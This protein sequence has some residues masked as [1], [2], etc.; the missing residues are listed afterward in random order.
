[1]FFVSIGIF[2][3]KD[4]YKLSTLFPNDL[5]PL[6]TLV[7]KALDPP[8]SYTGVL[9]KADSDMNIPSITQSMI[10]I[11]ILLVYY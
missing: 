3:I 9:L 2:K 6:I 8:H 4:V 7:I 1:M 11:S 5:L 10:L